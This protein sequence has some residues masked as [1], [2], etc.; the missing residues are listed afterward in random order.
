MGLLMQW[1]SCSTH[2]FSICCPRLLTSCYF[3]RFFH[4]T[5][6]LR[7]LSINVTHENNLIP[8]VS[9]PTILHVELAHN[10]KKLNNTPVRAW[11]LHHC[12]VLIKATKMFSA[13]ECNRTWQGTVPE[14]PAKVYG[15]WCIPAYS[16]IVEC[17][18]TIHGANSMWM[19]YSAAATCVSF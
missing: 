15:T 12:A 16:R 5:K 10:Y 17:I 8:A 11:N 4:L 2:I 7:E 14:T 19:E 9:W 6:R 13:L 1:S 18:S 3:H